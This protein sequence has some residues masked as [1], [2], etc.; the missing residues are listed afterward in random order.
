MKNRR[1]LK[2]DRHFSRLWL[3][4][5]EKWSAWRISGQKNTLTKIRFFFGAI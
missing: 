4:V 5:D 3:G 2:N 1:F